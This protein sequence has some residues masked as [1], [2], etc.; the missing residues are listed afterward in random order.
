MTKHK[1]TRTR[2]LNK[3]AQQNSAKNISCFCQG[4]QQ[5]HKVDLSSPKTKR[6]TSF[7]KV[8]LEWPLDPIVKSS[9]IAILVCELVVLGGDGPSLMW[10]RGWLKGVPSQLNL[11]LTRPLG[12]L[13]MVINHLQVLWWSQKIQGLQ[14]LRI[15]SRTYQSILR[16]SDWTIPSK[17]RGLDLCFSQVSGVWSQLILKGEGVRLRLKT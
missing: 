15:E 5:I 7:R 1:P 4:T 13:T 6:V 11:W 3:A 16:T 8:V 17:Q 10:I 12:D 9:R 2:K 14:R